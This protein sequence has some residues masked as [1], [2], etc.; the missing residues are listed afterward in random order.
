MLIIK[1]RRFLKTKFYKYVILNTKS[2]CDYSYELVP[3]LERVKGLSLED[4]SPF[5]SDCYLD[6]S[7]HI[8]GFS[9]FLIV[10]YQDRVCCAVPMHRVGI[11]SFT[12]GYSGIIFSAS[13]KES[14][15]RVAINGL[16]LFL[17]SNWFFE[18]RL[19][20]GLLSNNFSDQRNSLKL[21]SASESAFFKFRSVRTLT[22][23]NIDKNEALP[24]YLYDQKA[25]NQIKK[26]DLR[27]I[28]I[29][30]KLFKSSNLFLQSSDFFENY[31]QLLSTCRLETGMKPP[32][33]EDLHAELNSIISGGGQ[34]LV[35]YSSC[36]N[37]MVSAVVFVISGNCSLYYQGG[38]LNDFKSSNVYSVII[39][40]AIMCSLDNGVEVIEMGRIDRSSE[41]NISID[42]FKSQ[43]GADL[44]FSFELNSKPFFVTFL[45]KFKSLVRL[46]LRK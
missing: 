29:A 42:R 33:K 35:A 11:F 30:T 25:R 14:K 19:L 41:K 22:K 44:I 1:M 32:V 38:C 37:V 3:S 46:M 36:Q 10:S 43:F 20:Q 6:A 26:C 31:F 17:K 24:I 4:M 21:S 23:L 16:S 2:R 7:R 9:K 13:F 18:F 5:H 8:N 28:D 15:F 39:D 34:V 40:R 45:R 12:S 27:N